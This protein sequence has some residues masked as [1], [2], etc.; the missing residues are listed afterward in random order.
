MVTSI[1]A[2]QQPTWFSITFSL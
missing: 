1:G 2:L